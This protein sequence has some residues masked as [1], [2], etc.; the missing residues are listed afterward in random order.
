MLNVEWDPESQEK[1]KGK[2][3]P[4]PCVSWVSFFHSLNKIQILVTKCHLNVNRFYRKGAT[5]SPGL[6]LAPGSGL[7]RKGKEW[8]TE[9]MNKWINEGPVV[10]S[11]WNRNPITARRRLNRWIAKEGSGTS[12]MRC[13]RDVTGIDINIEVLFIMEKM[14]NYANAMRSLWNLSHF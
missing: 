6:A 13:G 1:P 4:W 9:I 10:V 3:F 11:A 5:R 2:A 8:I 12:V 7:A 14:W